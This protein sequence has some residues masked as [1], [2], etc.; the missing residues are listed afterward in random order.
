[1]RLVMTLVVT[2]A[3]Y[4]SISK[5]SGRTR[6]VVRPPAVLQSIRYHRHPRGLKE[7]T[8]D[9]TNH[10]ANDKFTLLRPRRLKGDDARVCLSFRHR[11]N[12][13][14]LTYEFLLADKGNV[15]I[16]GKHSINAG[17]TIT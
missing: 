9:P 7:P 14:Q 5:T 6:N 1:M 12:Q 3:L 13:S 16:R 10:Q 2:Y 17:A 11:I 4:S 8:Q 15:T